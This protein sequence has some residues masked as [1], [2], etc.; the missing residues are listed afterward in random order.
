LSLSGGKADKTGFA[1]VEYF[2]GQKKIFLSSLVERIQNEDG[3]S[4]D[5]QIHRMIKSVGKNLESVSVDAPLTWPK[6]VRCKLKCPGFE[7]C[8]EPE[9]KWM[10]RFYSRKNADK[11][12]F[13]V[14]TPYTERCSELFLEESLEEK[15]NLQQAGGS[16]RAPL[17]ARIHFIQRRLKTKFIEVVPKISFWRMGL[18]LGL[19]KSKLKLHRHWDGG[20][21]SRALFIEALLKHNVTFIYEQDK[22]VLIEDAY[23]F[24]AFMAAL[25]GL[26]KYQKQTEP[27]PRGF[28]V[29]EGWIEI[30]KLK[31]KWP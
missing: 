2:P 29:K 26:M 16:N 1:L 31:L 23:A 19:A 10:S 7:K 30:P 17:M 12:P 24:D 8:S 13:K 28:P 22:K 21:E 5:L 4:A 6:C 15:F 11:R 18:S 20:S 27:R 9:I 14:M 25:T 3:I